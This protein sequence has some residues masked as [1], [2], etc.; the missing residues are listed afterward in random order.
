M[1]ISHFATRV[2]ILLTLVESLIFGSVFLLVGTVIFEGR[3]DSIGSVAINVLLPTG[4]VLLCLLVVGGY[5]AEAWRS[6]RTMLRRIV[7][8]GIGGAIAIVLLHDLFIG[9]GK[10]AI[11]I[12]GATILG[13]FLAIGGRLLGKK[14][15]GGQFKRQVLVLGAGERARSL[16][17]SLEE[18]PL[19]GVNIAGFLPLDQNGAPTTAS[20]PSVPDTSLRT[21]QLSL[22]DYARKERVAELV[23]ALDDGVSTPIR[24]ALL[25]CRLHGITVTDRTAFLE[26]EAG[27][28]GLEVLSL[29][30]LIYS[31]GFRQS[32][33]RDVAKRTSDILAASTL[34]FLTL[35]LFPV[36]ALLVKLGSKGPAIYSQ[37]R[38][39]LHGEPFT[40]Y[41]FRS[42]CNDA[43]ANGAQWAVDND[44]R[45]TRLGKILRLT[46]LDELPQLW[47][48]L[49]GDMSLVGPR[50][51][52]PEMI[53]ELSEQ[54]PYYQERH[55]VRPGITGWA[56]TSYSYTSSVEDTKVKL[57]YDLYYLKNHSLLLDLVI[58]F[59]T[60]R[61]ALRG[62]GA[63]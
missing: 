19:V 11:E 16:M 46:R 8:A 24:H 18:S 2:G 57:E 63:R 28:I 35:P 20:H 52:R 3:G 13:C 4:L 10:T 29:E 39:G 21:T 48:V 26:R 23:L 31:P 45:V 5:R 55:G 49:R 50:P 34:L 59:Q 53:V 15:L 30:W 60:I 38:A 56:Q 47:N 27:R 37:I 51:E 33:L 41:K 9:D 58:M 14:Y 17:Q 32:R 1:T 40:M 43:E 12:V 22:L 42:M 61:V 44:P 6:P 7:G 54:I 62:I 25:A 36:I